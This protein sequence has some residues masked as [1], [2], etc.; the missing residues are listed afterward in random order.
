[1][2]WYARVDVVLNLKSKLKEFGW[3]YGLNAHYKSAAVKRKY[4]VTAARYACL[5]PSRSFQ[6]LFGKHL[7]NE[8]HFAQI[9]RPLRIFFMGT[10]EQQDRSGTLQALAKISELTYFTRADGSY[11]QNDPSLP[12]FRK[13][14][15]TERLS[16]LIKKHADQGKPPDVL[17]AQTWAILVA[18]E[19]LSR[20]RQAYG[21]FIINISMD[22][23]HQYWGAKLKGEWGGTFPLIPHIDLALTAAPECADWYMKEG[24][25]AVFFPEASDPEI[26]H[27]MPELPKTHDVCFVGGCYGIREQIVNALQNAGIRVSAF[28]GGWKGGRIDTES[29]PKLFAQSK[30]VL[31][32]GTIG[33]CTDF[34]ALKMR[35][36]DGPMS[37]S[38][39]ITH[40]NPDLYHV[41]EIG[42]EIVTYQSISDCIDKVN[43][44]LQNDAE[45]EQIAE[46]GYQRAVKEHTWEKR[47]RTL[48]D[49]LKN[50][51]IF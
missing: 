7:K 18:P 11:G 32:V 25:P 22:D 24:C 8:K 16:T 4:R 19:I 37:G 20:I 23:R 3:L 26:F 6:E 34:F 27:P 30:I 1:M 36:F 48:T 10:D 12:L 40:D 45:R 33:H 29:V 50:G 35:D 39:Y 21:T 38:C 41:Y 9:D 31:G 2:Q 51:G 46:A 44:L 43:Y 28:G 14:A 5:P 15:N 49:L 47:F 13:R 42:K 17:I